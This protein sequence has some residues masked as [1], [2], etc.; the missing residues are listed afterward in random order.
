ML[1][2]FL[3]GFFVTVAIGVI[4]AFLD[5]VF[6]LDYLY[7]SCGGKCRVSEDGMFYWTCDRCGST[8]RKRQRYRRFIRG[9]QME[10]N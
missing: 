7:C 4:V 6:T 2:S 10:D 9:Q 3:V 5:A 1:W 8:I